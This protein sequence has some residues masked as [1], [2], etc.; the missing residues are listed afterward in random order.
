LEQHGFKAYPASS[1]EAAVNKLTD[2]S[3]NLTAYEEECRLNSING[4]KRNLWSECIKTWK[5][6][7]LETYFCPNERIQKS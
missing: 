1:I 7:Y 4:R 6:A 3:L 2:V 5:N